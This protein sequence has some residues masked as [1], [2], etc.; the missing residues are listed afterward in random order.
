MA[1]PALAQEEDGPRVELRRPV[2]PTG[3][4]MMWLGAMTPTS[5]VVKAKLPPGTPARLYVR[6]AGEAPLEFEPLPPRDRAS[7][8]ATFAIA[9]LSPGTIFTYTLDVVNRPSFYPPGVFRTF[10]A[11]G[12]ASSFAFAFG[13]CA[14][15]GSEHAVFETVREKQ[16]AVFLHLGDFHYQNISRDNPRLYRAAWDTVLAS[17]TQGPLYRDVPL[18]YVWDDHDF[19]PNDADRR[20]PGHAAARS[21]YREYAP[22]YPLPAGDG[23]AA[24]YQAFSIGRVR[25]I[26]SD[27]RGERA[28]GK[29]PDGPEKTMLGAAQK[30]WL[31]REL[32]ASSRSHALVFWTS[33]VPWIGESPGDSWQ[34]YRHERREIAN[35]IAEHRI[36]NLCILCGDAHMLAADDGR[37]TNYADGDS[38][39]V[40]VLHGSAL[41]Q[42]GSYKG[43]PYSHGFYTPGRGEGCFG[44]VQVL[45]D[46]TRVTVDYSG[47]NQDDE[48]KVALKF[49]VGGP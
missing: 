2:R 41:D 39:P 27:L 19:G 7:T 42:S 30:E 47:R 10:P 40:P 1:V 46:G 3:I 29:V 18:A 43:G 24:I 28:P 33:S 14:R 9:G 16:P 15:T 22:H 20:A 38:P 6:T 31:K 11:A 5:A 21:V 35:F 8:V 17:S 23:D 32:L 4:P 49:S 45:D 37:E 36:A 25:F 44:W 48:V 12:T 13:S 26:M 34:N